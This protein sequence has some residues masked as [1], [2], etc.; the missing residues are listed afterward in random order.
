MQQFFQKEKFILKLLY[1]VFVRMSSEIEQPV[2]DT[3][4]AP[5]PHETSYGIQNVRYIFQIMT[6]AVALRQA[7]HYLLPATC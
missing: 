2:M 6:D 1:S 4:A 5:V 3:V 7:V